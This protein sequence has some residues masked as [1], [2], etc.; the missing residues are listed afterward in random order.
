ML[1]EDL[2][3]EQHKVPNFSPNYYPSSKVKIFYLIIFIF[4]NFYFKD[5]N[6]ESP[7]ITDGADSYSEEELFHLEMSDEA[8]SG[9][10][11]SKLHYDNGIF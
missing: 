7:A 11:R 8:C 4:S 1:S 6:D 5:F 2:Y 3:L 9:G 10:K